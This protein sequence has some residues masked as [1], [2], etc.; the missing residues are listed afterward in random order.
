M[1][2]TNTETI[3]AS[4]ATLREENYENITDKNHNYEIER[5]FGFNT[6]RKDDKRDGQMQS[7]RV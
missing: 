4:P 1:N 7:P 5:N 2:N 3:P 6:P